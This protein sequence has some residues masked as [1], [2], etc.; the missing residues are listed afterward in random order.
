V[1]DR[2]H[3]K[4]PFSDHPSRSKLTENG[5]RLG[6][7][8]ALYTAGGVRALMDGI[9]TPPF[10]SVPQITMRRP[11]RRLRTVAWIARLGRYLRFAVGSGRV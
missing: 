4:A 5:P 6:G 2:K 8:A 10:G 7:A 11:R 3:V 1:S 9:V